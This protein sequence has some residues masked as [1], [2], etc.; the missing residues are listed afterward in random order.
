M[1]WLS[2]GD[3]SKY[4]YAFKQVGG[5]DIDL[6]QGTSIPIYAFLINGWKIRPQESNH[7][8]TVTEGVILVDGGGDPFVNTLSNY[9]VRINYQQ[10][11]QAISFSSGG[12]SLTSAQVWGHAL[13]GGM[14][15][16]EMMR[17]FLSVL[18]GKVSGASTATEYFRDLLDTKNRV[19]STVDTN[20]NRTAVVVDGS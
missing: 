12:S 6:S 3:N 15:A 13:E 17:V 20:G 11:V 10:P 2:T 4:P 9:V 16:E 1:N 19:I 7:T 14:S 18:A 5:D 8:L